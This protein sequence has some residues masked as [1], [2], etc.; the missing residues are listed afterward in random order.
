MQFKRSSFYVYYL[1]DDNNED[2]KKGGIE[3]TVS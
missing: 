1:F 2:I 3:M